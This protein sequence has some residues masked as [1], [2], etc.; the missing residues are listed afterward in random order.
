MKRFISIGSRSMILLLLVLLLAASSS[1]WLQSLPMATS[2]TKTASCLQGVSV[3]GSVRPAS[4]TRKG[5]NRW[6]NT[7]LSDSSSSTPSTEP[8]NVK[9]GEQ[10]KKGDSLVNRY[11]QLITGLQQTPT[12]TPLQF[13]L[14]EAEIKHGRIAMLAAIGW[15]FSELYHYQLAAE[16]Y[17]QQVDASNPVSTLLDV[18]PLAANGRAP[19][20][21]NGGLD[22]LYV[23]LVLGTFFAVGGILEFE[24]FR[25]RKAV[26]STL[27]NFY[28]LWREDGWDAPGNYGFGKYIIYCCFLSVF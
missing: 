9:T 26:P 7:A 8:D 1:A 19:S 21:L 6:S 12:A 28:D 17:G 20:V 11:L 5:G 24:L 22:N 2:C 25:R 3:I 14:R 15:P 16:V 13:A 10:E 23:L 4:L 27:T 18:I